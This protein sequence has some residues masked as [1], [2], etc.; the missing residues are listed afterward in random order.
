MG[1]RVFFVLII[2]F[3]FFQSTI[4][5]SGKKGRGKS[6][7]PKK[8][9]VTRSRHGRG[10][11]VGRRMV[12]GRDDVMSN[13]PKRSGVVRTMGKTVFVPN[14]YAS[15]FELRNRMIAVCLL[16]QQILQDTFLENQH[17]QQLA[18]FC[19]R[20]FLDLQNNLVAGRKIPPPFYDLKKGRSCVNGALPRNFLKV[21]K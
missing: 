5:F 9:V 10:V 13:Y 14:P 8:K 6:E 12:Y 17:R 16:R 1:T 7:W 11:W 18:D 2:L 19:A 21:R 20:L 15:D 3:S 4:L